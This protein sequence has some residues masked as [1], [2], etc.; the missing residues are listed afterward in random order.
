MAQLYAANAHVFRGVWGGV[1][2]EQIWRLLHGEDL[3]FFEQQEGRTLGHGHVL[4]P[5]KRNH[6]DALAVLHRLLQKAAMRLRH[7]QYYA[8]AM[9]VSVDYSDETR[10]SSPMC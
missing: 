10:W 1:R 5:A 8:N 4:P 2:G 6:A 9:S 7:S 3:D